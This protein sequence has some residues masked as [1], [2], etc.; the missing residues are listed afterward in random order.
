MHE[1]RRITCHAVDVIAC[2][3]EQGAKTA[4]AATAD[5]AKPNNSTAAKAEAAGKAGSQLHGEKV[6]M[7]A[8]C[9]WLQKHVCGHVV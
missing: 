1:T 6:H 9:L 5:A 2:H 3:G 4:T 7:Q 8:H